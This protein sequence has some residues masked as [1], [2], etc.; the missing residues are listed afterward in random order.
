MVSGPEDAS[1][2]GTGRHGLVQALN[3]DVSSFRD[4]REEAREFYFEDASQAEVIQIADV[5]VET[6]S[7]GTVQPTGDSGPEAAGL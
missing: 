1:S 2:S 5:E 4:T 3:V 6:V 7:V